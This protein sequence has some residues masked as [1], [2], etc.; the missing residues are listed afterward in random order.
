M[1]Q[2]PT[3]ANTQQNQYNQ[4]LWPLYEDCIGAPQQRNGPNRQNFIELSFNEIRDEVQQPLVAIQ[5]AAEVYEDENR[6]IL[7]NEV[8]EMTKEEMSALTYMS[9]FEGL[10]AL[11]PASQYLCFRLF[12]SPTLH[13]RPSHCVRSRCS[14]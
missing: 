5:E 7:M 4:V 14:R 8:L 1:H 3:E 10:L 11:Q 2:E 6:S 9:H 12:S 13:L